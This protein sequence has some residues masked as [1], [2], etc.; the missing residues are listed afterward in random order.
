MRGSLTSIPLAVLVALPLTAAPP[1]GWCGKGD[2][3]A[4]E[5]LWLHQEERARRGLPRATEVRASAERVGEIAVLRDEG[6]LALFRKNFDLQ[7]VG[8]TMA[9]Q[10]DVYVVNRADRP[11]A[12]GTGTRLGLADDDSATVPLPFAFAFH[13]RTWNEVFVNSDGNLTF[14]AGDGASTARDIGRLVNGP[15][16]IA[17]ML[18]DLD[19]ASGGHVSWTADA[20]R[21]TVTWTQVPQFDVG[22]SN[23]FEVTLRADGGIEF[24]YASSVATGVK[25]GAVGIAPGEA[26]NGVTPIDFSNPAGAQGAGALAETFRD[27]DELDTAAVARKFFAA[28]PD[29][30]MQLVVFTSRRMAGVGTFAFEQTV[31]NDISGIGST[32]FDFAGDYGSGG[33]LESFVMMDTISKYPDDFASPLL[34]EESALSILSHETGHR[35]LALA[36][37][38]AEG[39]VSGELLGRQNAHWSFF[40]DS[41]GSHLEGNQISD[42]GGGQFRTGADHSSRYGELDQY[43][44]GLRGPDEVPPFFFVRSPTGLTN[45]S[46]ARSPAQGVT[47]GGTRVDVTVGQVVSALGTR[48]PP[49]GEAPNAHR[50]AW[51]FVAIGGEPDA[52][53][54]AKI[55]RLRQQ[56]PSYYAGST[57]GRASVSVTL[58]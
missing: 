42:L 47:F 5:A 20:S 33:R 25:E 34:G 27:S 29:D 31:K 8:L 17:P 11:V 3:T 2:R 57:D 50:Q 45:S 18:A 43:L 26:R 15:P 51:V 39:R 1:P 52:A 32:V 21:F 44:M 28:Y 30:Y 22:D 23:T 6:D 53:Q 7:S 38:E 19:P 37:F 24:A 12:G 36:R 14:G 35:W 16:R 55:D 58:E 9:P 40:M 10:G 54:I 41:N 56:F 48:T 13:G 46:P 4:R 49:V